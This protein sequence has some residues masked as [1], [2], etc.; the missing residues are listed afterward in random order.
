MC[1]MHLVRRESF[2]NTFGPCIVVMPDRSNSD[3]ETPETIP[4][5]PVLAEPMFD[6]PEEIE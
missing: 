4:A 1:R 6:E 5:P 3:E 2:C